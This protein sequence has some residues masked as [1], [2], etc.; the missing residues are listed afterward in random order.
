MQNF[1]QLVQREVLDRFK[2]KYLVLQSKMS[3]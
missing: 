2:V 3:S 1:M